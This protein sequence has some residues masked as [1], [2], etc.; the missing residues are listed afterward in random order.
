MGNKQEDI[1]TSLDPRM[2]LLMLILFTTATY[3]SKVHGY[4]CGIILSL[5]LVYDSTPLE[6]SMANR[7]IVWELFDIGIS[8]QFYPP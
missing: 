8:H 7:N 5:W 4:C 6:R 2:K 1:Y 3:I